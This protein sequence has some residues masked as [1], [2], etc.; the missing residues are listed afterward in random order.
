MFPGSAPRRSR[1]TGRWRHGRRS[2]T[3]WIL[4]GNA[5]PIGAGIHLQLRRLS[6]RGLYRHP[7]AG[8]L[9]IGPLMRVTSPPSW[10]LIGHWRVLFPVVGAQHVCLGEGETTAVNVRARENQGSVQCRGRVVSKVWT[11]DSATHRSSAVATRLEHPAGRRSSHHISNGRRSRGGPRPPRREADHNPHPHDPIPIIAK[12]LSRKS[13]EWTTRP[14]TA[15]Q[16]CRSTSA[17]HR[18]SRRSLARDAG[19]S[20]QSAPHKRRPVR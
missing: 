5:L 2:N 20:R 9:L 1:H 16:T 18:V 6:S 14:C 10:R 15:T 11:V 7:T 4:S 13:K 19:S 3:A 17:R 12:R 8:M